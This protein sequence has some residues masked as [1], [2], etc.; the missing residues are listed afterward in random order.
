MKHNPSLTVIVPAWNREGTIGRCLDSIFNQEYEDYEVIVVDD[1]STDG[2]LA[3]IRGYGED[4]IIV[5]C[6]ETNEGK[7]AALRDAVRVASA[8][9]IVVLDSDDALL[10]GALTKMAEL[11]GRVAQGV[12]V[13]GMK[14]LYDTGETTPD[15]PLPEGEFGL[16]EWLRWLDGAKKADMLLCRRRALLQEIP[17]P[18]D[19]RG[20][21]QMMLRSVA[22]WKFVVSRQAGGMVHTDAANRL[23]QHKASLL[24]LQAKRDH[25]IMTE[26][27]LQEF[28]A[29]L[30]R[31]APRRYFQLFFEAGRWYFLA[32]NRV[33]GTWWS[34]RFLA[35]R[36]WSLRGWG[37]FALGLLGPGTMLRVRR[38]L[39]RGQGRAARPT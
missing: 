20:R 8:E 31:F 29:A 1:G 35:R 5:L 26:E 33:K 19:L 6:H 10:P 16:E 9:W 36:P 32:G 17:F 7:N 25:A 13:V 4:R 15:P 22:R 27:I 11:A 39:R 37:I 2:T 28:G 23:G 38:V 34:L 21:A 3:A 30:R 14:M 18:A 24:P 12:G